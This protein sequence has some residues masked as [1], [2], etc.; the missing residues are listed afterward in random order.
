MF[1]G[2][3]R[4]FGNSFI[5][6]LDNAF[7]RVK[8]TL[9]EYN[10]AVVNIVMVYVWLKNIMNVPEMEKRFLDYFDKDKYPARTG[11]STECID[12]DCLFMMECIACRRELDMTN[13]KRITTQHSFS[14][15]V[16]AGDYVF[17]GH[18]RGA[19][20]DFN[21]Q[22]DNT[23]NKIIK[24]LGEFDLTLADLIK[25]NVHLKNIE[26]LPDMEKRFNNFFNKDH[27]PARMTTT[28][29]FIDDDC[30]MMID[31]VAYCKKV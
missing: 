22:F 16:A 12:D 24:T 9:S 13:V 5:T 8:K 19:G 3:Q 11:A 2:L 17:L 15:A 26:D 30:L 1:V 31:G 20:T 6:Q 29:K 14:S 4:G 7:S 21:Q 23:F 27:F 10:I 25:V 28:T 18:H